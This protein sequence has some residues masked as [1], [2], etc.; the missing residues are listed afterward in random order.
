MADERKSRRIQ[1]LSDMVEDTNAEQFVEQEGIETVETTL[2]EVEEVPQKEYTKK[3]VCTNKCWVGSKVQ[4]YFP[5]DIVDFAPGEF[6]P[7][8][9][10]PV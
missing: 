2:P 4:M 8:H 5:G 10:K 6:V 7:S 1:T 9:F 3:Y